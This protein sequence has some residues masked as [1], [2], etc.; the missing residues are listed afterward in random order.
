[1]NAIL[2]SRTGYLWLATPDGLLRFDGVRFAVYNRLT[3]PGLPS[4]NVLAVHEGRDGRLWVG[5]FRGLAVGDAHGNRPFE[6]VQG[7]G[8]VAVYS[9]AQDSDGTV[10]AMARRGL[11]RVEG[12]GVTPL[13]AEQG[14][15]GDR[16]RALAS[17]PAGGLWV[18][19]NQGLARLEGT[20]VAATYAV[21]DGLT[22]D[23]VLS[24]LVDGDGTLWVGTGRGVTRRAKGGAFERVSAAGT[25]VVA[26]LLQ[27]HDGSIWAGTR[28][29]LLRVAGGKA[30][31]MGRAAG[32]PDE[33]VAA[34]AEDAEGDLWVGT[35]AGGI[36]RLRDGR[37]RVYGKAQ[38]LTHEVI[39]SVL[40][41]RD[42]S[43]WIG[44]D[45]GGLNRLRGD[46]AGLATREKGFDEE[47]V[48]A[49][50]ED[51]AGRVWFSTEWHGLCRLAAGRV[52]CL[53][54]SFAED[55]VRCLL[56]DKDGR[57][58]AG[59]SE[60]LVR[61]DGRAVHPVAT[62]DGKKITVTSLAE[63]PSGKLWVGTTSGLAE[64]ENGAFRRVT[65]GGTPHADHV[66]SLHADAD[67]TLWLGTTDAGLQRLRGGRLASITSRQGLPSDS[68]ASVRDDGAGRVWLSTGQGILAIARG[69]L[70]AALDGRAARISAITITEADGLRDRECSAGVQPSMW[71]GHDG[72]L[73]YPTIAGVAVVDPRRVRLNTRAPPI[74]VEEIVADGRR[75]APGDSLNLPAGV[76]HLEIHYAAP[77]FVAPERMRF[78]HRLEGLDS[79]FFAAGADRVAHYT[80]LGPGSYRFRVRAAN[81]DGVWGEQDASVTFAVRPYFWQTPWFYALSACVGVL[82]AVA[83]LELRVRGLRHREQE[84]KRRVAEEMARVEVLG[85]LLPI[86][87]WCKKVRH[88]AGYWEQIEQYISSHSKLEFTHGI[89]P[90]C[91][92]RVSP[93]KE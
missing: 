30:D 86:C 3:S 19:T 92:T 46:R 50:Y 36:A 88:D 58:W 87:A 66:M 34:L 31:P 14:L 10:W 1:V 74:Q 71:L 85:G 44:T 70:E 35:E 79:A 33:H 90:E 78:E 25:R 67:G 89:C 48:Y 45:G 61:I 84:L 9:I 65:I 21:R 24:V 37:A 68:V 15:P 69:D 12:K 81:E 55:L 4:E 8:P 22:S 13:G 29:G 27:D 6:Q 52:D 28:D 39:W 42:G 5:T 7:V 93:P 83:I 17:D 64:V 57:M 72:R 26:A 76:R 2:P 63:G 80:A 75:V 23:D 51:R 49:L 32:L 40:E 59:T 20:R 47:N 53:T 16:Y 54:G 91:L 77:S 60:A 56:E 38:G 82:A 18:A 43:V 11:W 73:W 62:E 41:G